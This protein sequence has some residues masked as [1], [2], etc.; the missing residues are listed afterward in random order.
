MES[1]R[2]HSIAESNGRGSPRAIGCRNS[3]A[4]SLVAK[5]RGPWFNSRWR[6]L[7]LVTFVI[8]QVFGHNSPDCVR[9]QDLQCC[10]HAQIPH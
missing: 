5:A 7:S 2:N 6:H 8:S 4:R 10:D 3:V 1:E 9:D